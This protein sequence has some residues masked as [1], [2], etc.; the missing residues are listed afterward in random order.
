MACSVDLSEQGE[1]QKRSYHFEEAGKNVEYA[2]F[3]PSS[4]RHDCEAPLVVLLHGLYSN[5]HR[6]IRFEGVVEEAEKRGFVVVAPFGY[7]D[8][9]WY[10]IHRMA[11]GWYGGWRSNLAELS[12]QDVL[13]VLGITVQSFNIDR[14]RIFIMGHSMGGAGA[15]HLSSRYP[16]IW[17]G[18]APMSP[19]LPF[20]METL[21]PPMVHLPAM[22]VTGDQ[23]WI[24]PVNPVRK[25][26]ASMQGMGMHCSYRELKGSGHL[27]PAWRKDVIAEIFDFFDR[28]RRTDPAP[29]AAAIFKFGKD[30]LSQRP[31]LKPTAGTSCGNTH[32]RQHKNWIGAM[33]RRDSWKTAGF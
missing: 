1:I 8:H 24:T 26:V 18:L 7:N 16:E 31:E 28:H 6:V 13:N 32:T 10:G 19:G 29:E 4:Y 27:A 11:R 30:I 15:L 23:D 2:I 21:L 9:G 22:V 17:A 3:V 5:P 14:K 12:E 25:L 33:F 20:E